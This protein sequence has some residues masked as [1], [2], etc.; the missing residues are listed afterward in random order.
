MN[1]TLGPDHKALEGFDQ[2][3]E[4]LKTALVEEM[5]SLLKKASL[6]KDTPMPSALQKEKE[7]DRKAEQARLAEATNEAAKAKA[8]PGAS[9]KPM[10]RPR[11]KSPN[12]RCAF[13]SKAELK[14]R[15]LE[16]AKAYTATVKKI[17]PT[18]SNCDDL[19]RAVMSYRQALDQR[20]PM[21]LACFD[22]DRIRKID[23]DNEGKGTAYTANGESYEHTLKRLADA[24]IDPVVPISDEWL[25]PGAGAWLLIDGNPEKDHPGNVYDCQPFWYDHWSNSEQWYWRQASMELNRALRHPPK[26]PSSPCLLLHENGWANTL[27]CFRF[28]RPKVSQFPGISKSVVE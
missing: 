13:G 5:T 26:S 24:E 1:E 4:S 3:E 9:A 18:S 14:S 2:Y 16:Q 20:R 6:A 23:I 25:P 19:G 7:K 22:S 27:D 12:V 8:V 21:R 11:S 10:S 17:V 15:I 28:L